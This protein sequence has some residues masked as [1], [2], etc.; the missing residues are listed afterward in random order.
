MNCRIVLM[1]AKTHVRCQ[2]CN[3]VIGPSIV[4]GADKYFQVFNMKTGRKVSG[5]RYCARCE[6]YAHLNHTI[7][8]DGEDS[9]DEE[10]HLRSMEDYAA[11]RA[12]GCTEEYWN[13]RDAGY[14]Y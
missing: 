7:V 2:C 3:E 13:D 5:G 9:H 11:Y 10:R 6:K 8:A 4:E 12:A 14:A 1:T